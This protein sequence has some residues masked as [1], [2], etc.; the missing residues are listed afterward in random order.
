MVVGSLFI[1][2]C[3]FIFFVYFFFLNF[4]VK[5]LLFLPF[6][7]KANLLST[8]KC[9]SVSILFLNFFKKI[10]GFLG[11][12]LADVAPPTSTN[13]VRQSAPS[14]FLS[15]FGTSSSRAAQN[16]SGT[17]QMCTQLQSKGGAACATPP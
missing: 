9:R 4:P 15:N 14:A 6:F 10:L 7:H 5:P 3:S 13:I 1:L 11:S 12:R 8:K 16:V 17:Q 2:D